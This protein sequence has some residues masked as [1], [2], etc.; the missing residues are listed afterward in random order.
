MLI[1]VGGLDT[2]YTDEGSGG[3]V[4]LL[5]GWGASSQSFAG[6]RSELAKSFRVLTPDLAGFG[7]SQPPP[8]AWGTEEYARQVERWLAG[9]GVE[10]AAFVGHSFGGRISIRLASGQ[11]GLVSRLALVAGAGIRPRRGPR[12]HVRVAATKLVKWLF[13]LPG[14]GETGRRI[15]ARRLER[16]GSRDYRAAGRMRPTLVRVVNED[17]TGLLPAIQ[18]PTL[19]LWGSSDREVPRSAVEVMHAGIAHSRL[20]VFEGAGH[21]PFLDAPEEFGRTLTAFLR[22]E[23]SR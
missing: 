20:V 2:H 13:S 22:G 5:H 16:T 17:L 1:R 15:I 3:P 14:W 7:W 10:T 18:T 19:I 6:L 9:L 8:E 11:P 12:Y 23:G 4:V 21:F